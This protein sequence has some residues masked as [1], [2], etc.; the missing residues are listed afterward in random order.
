MVVSQTPDNGFDRLFA[1]D[2]NYKCGNYLIE[3]CSDLWCSIAVSHPPHAITD[4]V[5]VDGNTY[6]RARVIIVLV[7]ASNASGKVND[8]V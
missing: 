7:T 3:A 4:C 2:Q 5:K 8:F 1:I 6:R